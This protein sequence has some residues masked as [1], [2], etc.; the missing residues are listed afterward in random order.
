MVL[1]AEQME[2]QIWRS[3][4]SVKIRITSGSDLFNPVSWL[5]EEPVLSASVEGVQS[6]QV[7]VHW[8][9]VPLGSF[10]PVPVLGSG[11]KLKS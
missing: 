6:T 4:S 8:E 11:S 1:E 2:V 10:I 7:V 5:Q 3:L 9:C